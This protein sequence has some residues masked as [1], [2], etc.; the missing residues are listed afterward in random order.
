MKKIVAL[1]AL[2]LMFGTAGTEVALGETLAWPRPKPPVSRWQYQTLLN[3]CQYINSAMGRDRCRKNVGLNYR[4]GSEPN[5]DLDCRRYS[6]VLVCGELEL[7]PRQ[8]KCVEDSVRAGM[9]RRRSEVECYAF[10]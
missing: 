7:S 1:M 3:Q 5:P 9:T 2:T 6:S 8:L 10:G 4:I